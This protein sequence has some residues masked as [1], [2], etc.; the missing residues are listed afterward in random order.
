M[1]A[2]IEEKAF[3]RFLRVFQKPLLILIDIL[4]AASGILLAY[5]ARFDKLLTPIFLKHLLLIPLIIALYILGLF[6]NRSYRER[7]ISGI[8]V[9]KN[10]FIAAGG[11]TFGFLAILYVFRTK[12]GSFPSSIVFLSF[13]INSIFLSAIRLLWYKKKGKLGEEILFVDKNNFRDSLD[14][15]QRKK[16]DKVVI[17]RDINLKDLYI[18]LNLATGYNLKVSVN[19]RLYEKYLQEKFSQGIDYNLSCHFDNSNYLEKEVI[20]ILDVLLS[21]FALFIF[22]PFI[23]LVGLL[24]KLDSSGPVFYKQKRV[25]KDGKIFTLY[26]FRTMVEDA[27]KRT[28]PVWAS[29]N[30]YRI[31]KVGRI[32]RKIRLDELP[33]LYNVLKGD[34]SL[35][36]PRP[37]RPHFVKL[38]KALCSIRLAVKPG[39]TGLAQIRS[40]YDLKPS[41]KIKYDKLYIAKQSPGLYLEVILKTIPV[42]LLRRGW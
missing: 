34:M 12:L 32:L 2:E 14:E 10:V 38:H 36:G 4:L 26:K 11:A 25:G 1:I 15:M 22:S 37:E 8:E 17:T 21:L 28:G 23:L 35:V 19:P 30:D 6:L 18:L 41:H 5:L 20:R 9:F 31:T 27:E 7:F 3:D 13:L 16:P 40:F 33:Q 39:L 42:V 24:I 29:Q